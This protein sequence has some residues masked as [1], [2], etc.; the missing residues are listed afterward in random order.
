AGEAEMDDMQIVAK[1]VRQILRHRLVVVDALTE[2]H[3]IAEK[4]DGRPIFA[5]ARWTDQIRIYRIVRIIDHAP[6]SRIEPRGVKNAGPFRP[7]A[8]DGFGHGK[9]M[10]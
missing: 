3:R 7:P 9:A 10:R 8:D 2:G 1:R 6:A 4:G 5:G